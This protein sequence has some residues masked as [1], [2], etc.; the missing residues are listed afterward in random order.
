QRGGGRRDRD[1]D[2]LAEG[3]EGNRRGGVAGIGHKQ[4][5]RAG[6]ERT[7][8]ADG[9]AGD[10][11]R[12]DKGRADERVA[13]RLIDDGDRAAGRRGGGASQG[14]ERDREADRLAVS[15]RSR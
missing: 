14:A 2:G 10:R 4:S 7:G 9:A 3:G 13:V 6:G 8:E 12:R 15:G 1:G 5:V 11:A